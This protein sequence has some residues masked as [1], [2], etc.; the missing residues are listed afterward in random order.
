M[1]LHRLLILGER[2]SKGRG[3]CSRFNVLIFSGHGEARQAEKFSPNRG[4]KGAR[5]PQESPAGPGA[6]GNVLPMAGDCRWGLS[7]GLLRFLP[8]PGSSRAIASGNLAP[9]QADFGPRL[10][11]DP[12]CES[13]IRTLFCRAIRKR[14]PPN[15]PF[16]PRGGGRCRETGDQLWWAGLDASRSRFDLCRLA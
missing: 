8:T 7:G 6:G 15:V 1:T 3:N 2:R 14:L 11:A 9:G 16:N 5:N 4:H 10:V 12:F 13:A